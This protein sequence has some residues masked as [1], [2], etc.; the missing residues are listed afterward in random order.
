LAGYLDVVLESF[1]DVHAVGDAAV[2]VFVV[3]VV[4]DELFYFVE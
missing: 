3:G 2:D 4:D 1:D